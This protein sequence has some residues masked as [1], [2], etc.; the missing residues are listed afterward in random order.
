MT[1]EDR[2]SAVEILGD[3]G[4]DAGPALI[5][6]E[7]AS[8]RIPARYHDLGLAPQHAESHAAWDPGARA[9]GLHLA[10]ALASPMVASTVSRLVYD[11]NRPPEAASA[12]PEKSEL[13]EVPGNRGLSPDDRAERVHSVYA[14]FCEAVT[15]QI[16]ARQQRGHSTAL[17]T[18][19]SFAPVYFGKQRAVEIGI[20]HDTDKRLADAMLALAPKLPHRKIER[21]EPYGPADGVTHSLQIHGIAQR[22]PNVMIEVRNDL[23]RTPED[24]ARIGD[25][26][27]TMIGPALVHL[28]LQSQGAAH[29]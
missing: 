15:A 12:M 18:V 17:I 26:L 10:A 4:A 3:A 21:N 27:L 1:I 16:A 2:K 24:I 11:C 23:L 22:L 29:A 13:I 20:L 19:H 28:G 5:L 8:H 9:L 6:C 14:P 7:H 25:E